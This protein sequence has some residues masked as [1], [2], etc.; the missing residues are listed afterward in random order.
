[1]IQLAKQQVVE[2]ITYLE[3]G[4]L[5]KEVYRQSFIKINTRPLIILPILEFLES[6]TNSVNNKYLMLTLLRTNRLTYIRETLDYT[7]RL[8]EI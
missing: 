6:I 7:Q 1:M 4:P 2:K 8:I 5:K 3:S